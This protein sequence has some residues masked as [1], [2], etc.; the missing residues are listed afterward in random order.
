MAEIEEF[1]L[2]LRGELLQPGEAGYDDARSLYNAMI[3]KKPAFIV[4]CAGVADVL[5]AVRFG[6]A[7]NMVV[8]V[9][10]GGH[11]VSGTALCDGGMVIDLS[12]MKGVW[13]DEQ[14]RIA[15]V[16]AGLTW[17]EL[18]HELGAFGLG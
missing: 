8:A 6:R 17:E 5:R 1:R 12:P 4:R 11:N 13:V 14:G 15:R 2:G 3:D 16:E 18:N 9:R 7:S 10:G